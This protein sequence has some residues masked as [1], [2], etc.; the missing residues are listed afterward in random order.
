M[1]VAEG[2]QDSELNK[3]TSSMV[4]DIL[5]NDLGLDTR[6]TTLGHVQ[7]GGNAVAYDRML[8]TLQGVEAVQAVL[9]RE[10]LRDRVDLG[11]ALP[12]E[13]VRPLLHHEL[14]DE[15]VA[16]ET[17]D[18]ALELPDGVRVQVLVLLRDL[19]LDVLHERVVEL[20]DGAVVGAPGVDGEA[21][22]LGEE[23]LE[24]GHVL[25]FGVDVDHALETDILVEPDRPAQSVLQKSRSVCDRGSKRENRTDCIVE[26]QLILEDLVAMG[27]D[28][29]SQLSLVLLSGVNRAPF[30]VPDG[31]SQLVHDHG[32]SSELQLE[33]FSLI[34]SPFVLLAFG[35][36]HGL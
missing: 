1:I 21:L 23:V 20:V 22:L 31:R 16:R 25:G 33:L 27:V 18:T 9:E 34:C 6:I 14:R 12:D 17:G 8:A 11:L 26:L 10:A 5:S 13:V 19:V 7:R 24:E 4:K 3:I 30:S 29:V 35:K 15:D 2:A 28:L 36:A 32:L